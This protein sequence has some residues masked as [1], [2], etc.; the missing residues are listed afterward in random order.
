MAQS[1]PSVGAYNGKVTCT[2]AACDEGL[3]VVD[4]DTG[5]G[6]DTNADGTLVNPN[7][8]DIAFRWGSCCTDG[9]VCIPFS[10][11]LALSP[12]FLLYL[13]HTSL[14]YLSFTLTF[15]YA[16]HLRPALPLPSLT[17]FSISIF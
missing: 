5:E 1:T 4:D 8:F 12:F 13:N 14:L 15:K 2:G 17:P 16:L 11:S 6:P 7:N 10:L 9:F 3:L